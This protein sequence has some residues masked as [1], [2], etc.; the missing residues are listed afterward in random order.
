LTEHVSFH[1]TTDFLVDHFPIPRDEWFL[2]SILGGTF[3]GTPTSSHL[4]G[5]LADLTE[6]S[7]VAPHVPTSEE[8]DLSIAYLTDAAVS[9]SLAD[10]AATGPICS[11][12]DLLSTGNSPACTSDS[13]SHDSVSPNREWTLEPSALTAALTADSLQAFWKSGRTPETTCIPTRL[14][15]PMVHLVTLHL[16]SEL[17]NVVVR[18]ELVAC[19]ADDH[20]VIHDL[21]RRGSEH[22]EKA[23]VV[24]CL[25]GPQSKRVEFPQFALRFSTAAAK[26]PPVCFRVAVW[27]RGA[28]GSEAPLF[29]HSGDF[30][31]AARKKTP[32]EDAVRAEWRR[33]QKQVEK[34][35]RRQRAQGKAAL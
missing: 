17:A 9:A 16:S 33:N 15:K 12:Y 21:H 5:E 30:V 26:A 13:G 24:S 27:L 6:C 28:D 18:A 8:E 22:G 31:V 32:N 2:S 7:D 3:F 10:G 34:S 25:P 20:G 19:D 35:I 11:S 14:Y 4:C 1:P 23:L 29:I